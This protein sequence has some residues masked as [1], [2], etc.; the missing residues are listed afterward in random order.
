ML[1]AIVGKKFYFWNDKGQPLFGIALYFLTA[2]L[3]SVAKLQ[4]SANHAFFGL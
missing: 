3:L 1:V 2:F 4:Q